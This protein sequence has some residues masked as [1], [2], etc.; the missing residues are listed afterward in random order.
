[1]LLV[2]FW[3]VGHACRVGWVEGVIR[4]RETLRDN[5]AEIGKLLARSSR[6]RAAHERPVLWP[7]VGRYETANDYFDP[8]QIEVL[9]AVP[10]RKDPPAGPL[11]SAF[12]ALRSSLDPSDHRYH[13]W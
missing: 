2:L 13:W 3:W 4:P 8:A 10:W 12:E 6:D 11:R 1:M 5:G 7:S 9:E